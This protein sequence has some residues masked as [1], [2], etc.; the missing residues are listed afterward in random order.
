MMPIKVFAES[1]LKNHYGGQIRTSDNQ[2]TIRQVI[3][4]IRQERDAVVADMADYQGALLKPVQDTLFLR[5]DPLEMEWDPEAEV[6]YVSLP[7]GVL[8]LP[9]D[10]GIRVSPVR[11]LVNPYRRVPPNWTSARREISHAEGNKT[12]EVEPPRA[13]GGRRIRF[14]NTGQAEM[15]KVILDL[16]ITDSTALADTDISIPEGL[17]SMVEARVLSRLGHSR[18]IDN[19]NDNRDQP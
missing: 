17:R 5:M 9:D 11:G 7:Y 4:L 2:R 16:V 19:A 3:L 1:I 12:W 14:P 13:S 10:K 15:G 8:T 6:A 18:Q